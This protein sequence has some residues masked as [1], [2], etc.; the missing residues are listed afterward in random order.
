MMILYWQLSRLATA[1]GSSFDAHPI[2]L[3]FF[4]FLIFQFFTCRTS[5]LQSA[6][7]VHQDSWVLQRNIKLFITIFIIIFMQKL[8]N[9]LMCFIGALNENLP[10]NLSWPKKLPLKAWDQL[11]Q[12]MAEPVLVRCWFISSMC[13]P[14]RN[15]KWPRDPPCSDPIGSLF[16]MPATRRKLREDFIG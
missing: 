15:N 6:I 2:F 13:S 1:A 16:G 7:S 14:S 3:C 8:I 4:T 5:R 11:K 12:T 10:T 9:K